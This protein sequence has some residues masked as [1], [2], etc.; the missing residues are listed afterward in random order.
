[1]IGNEV[2]INSSPEVANMRIKQQQEV[3]ASNYNLRPRPQRLIT[4]HPKTSQINHRKNVEKNTRTTSLPNHQNDSARVKTIT[5]ST[6]NKNQ[7]NKKDDDIFMNKLKY[8]CTILLK[9]II[10]LLILVGIYKTIQMSGLQQKDF[11]FNIKQ[12][13]EEILELEKDFVNQSSNLWFSII[14]GMKDYCIKK[15]QRPF[16]IVL[17]DNEN[18]NTVE[19]LAQ[20]L[21]TKILTSLV[22]DAPVRPVILEAATLQRDDFGELM[23]ELK[24]IVMLKKVLVINNVQV[25]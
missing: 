13:S 2:I 3:I 23:E 22:G 8:W 12:F 5:S 19:C 9:I 16:V 7:N 25:K 20:V 21:A 10:F 4:S 24:S 18:S 17:F 6:I 11:N 14:S 1:M 15:P